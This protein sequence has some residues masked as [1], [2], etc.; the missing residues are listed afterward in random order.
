MVCLAF[1]IYGWIGVR[2]VHGGATVSAGGC[3]TQPRL[4]IAILCDIWVIIS[5]YKLVIVKSALYSALL[6][7][8]AL[9]IYANFWFACFSDSPQ[10]F[11][12]FC[13]AF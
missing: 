10:L 3:L 13:N 4:S 7:C 1:T 5:L 2:R 9:Y 11:P 8:E 6:R 12:A